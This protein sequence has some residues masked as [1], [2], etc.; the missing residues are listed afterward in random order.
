MKSAKGDFVNAFS[1]F[2]CHVILLKITSAFYSCFLT[3]TDI[4]LQAKTH[5]GMMIHIACSSHLELMN[6]WYDFL[7]RI[8]T[9]IVRHMIFLLGAFILLQTFLCF[10]LLLTLFQHKAIS[11]L[12][13]KITELLVQQTLCA[14]PKKY[15]PSSNMQWSVVILHRLVYIIKSNLIVFLMCSQMIAPLSASGVVLDD[16]ESTKLLSSVAIALSN[17]GR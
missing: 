17:C 7:C 5:T 12:P 16:P 15:S 8:Y 6:F 4:Y 13:I 2:V 14:P 3:V 11:I 10:L 9:S 1:K